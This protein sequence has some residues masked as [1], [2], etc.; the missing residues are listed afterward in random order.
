M[1]NSYKVNVTKKSSLGNEIVTFA[2]LEEATEE[3]I[4]SN[5]SPDWTFDWTSLW[6]KA[7]FE[8]EAIIK[9]SFNKEVLGLIR[10]ALYP[11]CSDNLEPEYL[12]ILHL[13]CISNVKRFIDPVG[14]WLL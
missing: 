6:N 14:F 7:D 2:Y 5:D 13:E 3:D 1:L 12:E 10:F 11:F 4:P 8:C 9:L